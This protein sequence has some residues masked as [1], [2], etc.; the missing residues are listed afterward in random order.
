MIPLWKL[1]REAHRLLQQLNALLEAPFRKA[2]TQ[3]HDK[4]RHQNNRVT[5]GQCDP[6]TGIAIFLLF[7]PRGLAESVFQ[8]IEW[9]LRQGYATLIVS[10]SA[11]NE[12]DRLKLSN[13]CWRIVERPNF[14]YDFGGYR[15]GIMQIWDSGITPERLVIFNDS[16]W[17]PLDTQTPLLKIAETLDAD[18]IGAIK[19]V[20]KNAHWLESYFFYIPKRTFLNKKFVSFWQNYVLTSNKYLVIRQGERD[21][22]VALQRGGLK[23]DAVYS[24]ETLIKKLRLVEPEILRNTLIYGSYGVAERANEAHA[25]I[26]A[27]LPTQSWHKMAMDHIEITLEKAGF[28]SQYCY[29]SVRFIG[30][31]FLKKSSDRVNKMWRIAYLSAIEAGELELPPQHILLEL[32]SAVGREQTK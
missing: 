5:E 22:G 25:L 21:F 6:G 24:S 14:G 27:Y 4:L 23:L 29:G 12:V 13:I 26:R 3:R 19:R 1:S 7:Q 31:P 8:Q 32:Q 17:F 2:R 10:N 20:K 18:I 16:T 9:L 15:E 11:I 28:N 30:F